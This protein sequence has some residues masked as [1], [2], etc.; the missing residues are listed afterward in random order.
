MQ[1]VRTRPWCLPALHLSANTEKSRVEIPA[2]ASSTLAFPPSRH[3]LTSSRRVP[4]APRLPVPPAPRSPHQACP[5]NRTS[6]S[7]PRLL[8]RGTHLHRL[9]LSVPLPS[10]QS[11]VTLGSQ[12]PPPYRLLS[13]LLLARWQTP[14]CPL[15][16]DVPKTAT[17]QMPTGLDRSTRSSW[18]PAALL[19]LTED[20]SVVHQLDL[21]GYIT[22]WREQEPQRAPSPSLMVCKSAMSMTSFPHG[23]R[24][25][26]LRL[27][28]ATNPPTL[29]AVL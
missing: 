7:Q 27:P 13:H 18:T 5:G 29:L 12:V 9:L 4:S 1:S 15:R 10:P 23:T 3:V 6:L 16:H 14:R 17:S 8:P 26:S 28:V 2:T 24:Q 11:H 19:T 20:R 21:G 22:E 25:R